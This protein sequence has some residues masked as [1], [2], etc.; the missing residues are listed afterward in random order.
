MHSLRVRRA[1]GDQRC[2]ILVSHS[3]RTANEVSHNRPGASL[4]LPW[5]RV[6]RRSK[7]APAVRLARAWALV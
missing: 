4:F 6:R 7:G 1:K 3:T 5:I 2:P